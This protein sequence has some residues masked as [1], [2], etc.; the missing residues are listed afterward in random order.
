MPPTQPV[1]DRVI[2]RCPDT[3]SAVALPSRTLLRR[4]ATLDRALRKADVQSTW[5]PPDAQV[6]VNREAR[7]YRF[8]SYPPLRMWAQRVV[9]SYVPA[10]DSAPLASPLG[11]LSA[12]VLVGLGALFLAGCAQATFLFPCLS[13]FSQYDSGALSYCVPSGSLAEAMK[14]KCDAS[15]ASL[16]SQRIPVTMQTYGV[17][18]LG[19]VGG[20]TGGA[21]AATLY[22]VMVCL[23][24]PFQASSLGVGKAVWSYGGI[25]S[26]SGG[27]FWGFIAAAAI[28]GRG[29]EVGVGRGYSLRSMAWLIPYMLGAQAAI[30]ACGLFWLPFG[31]ALARKVSPSAI[32]PENKGIN[33]CLYN[34]FNWG[35]VPYLPGECF[36]MA[37]ILATVPL[38]WSIAIALHKWRLGQQGGVF[39]IV[40]GADE[41]EEEEAEEGGGEKKVEV[42]ESSSSTALE[43]RTPAA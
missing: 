15:V 8:T 33:N 40:E 26:S 7:T 39:A 37:L 4:P 21:L 34:I 35:M 17:M 24:A 14:A 10:L 36:K 18:L 43:V 29:S 9:S 12:V 6:I 13:G 5:L 25:L 11:A 20:R 22:V 2:F 3:G 38:A 30:Y 23:G 42:D 41:E 1:S 32:C 31:M 28:M 27:F 16:C 19:A